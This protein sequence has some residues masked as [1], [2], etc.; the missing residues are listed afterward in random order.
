MI[1]PL[2]TWLLLAGTATL[3]AACCGSVSCDCQDGSADAVVFRFDRDSTQGGTGFRAAELT[4]VSI[5]RVPLDNTQQLR[6]DSVLLTRSRA[7]THRPIIINNAQPLA[8]NGTRKLN[9]YRYVIRL[10]GQNRQY[11][12]DQIQLDGRFEADGCCTC[13][14]NTQKIVYFNRRAYNQTVPGQDTVVLSR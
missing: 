6:P 4:S 7:T 9:Q 13:Y 8:P 2:L 14:R 12:F 5:R 1:R 10:S 11:S 3:T